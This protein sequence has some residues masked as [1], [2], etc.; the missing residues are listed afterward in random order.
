MCRSE[1]CTAIE[2]DIEQLWSTL[3]NTRELL[4]LLCIQY[5][6]RGEIKNHKAD[7]EESQTLE[8]EIQVAIEK[9]HEAITSQAQISLT[10]TTQESSVF[11]YQATSANL[12]GQLNS[13]SLGS[14]S[15]AA[16]SGNSP[17]SFTASHHLKPLKVPSYDGDKTRFEECWD[18]FQSL[19]DC[20]NGLVNLKMARLHQ[21]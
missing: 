9:A 5:L 3:E 10:A 13:L 12:G 6:E 21:S 20:S 17:G 7:S 18:L 8:S 11:G 19:A 2:H 14:E 15:T 1:G 16:A 4:D